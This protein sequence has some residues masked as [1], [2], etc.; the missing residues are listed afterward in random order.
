LQPLVGKVNSSYEQAKGE[1]EVFTAFV[2]Q[3]TGKI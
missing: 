3:Q 1:I 2:E